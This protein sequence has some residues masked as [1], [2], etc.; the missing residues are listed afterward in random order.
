MKKKLLLFLFFSLFAL[1]LT[2]CYNYHELENLAIV[3]GL[4]I[5]KKDN[6]YVIGVLVANSKKQE[7]SSKEGQSQTIVY[8]GKGNS[9]MEAFYNIDLES[10]KQLYIGHLAVVVI[11]ENIAKNEIEKI[12]DI[13]I[14]SPESR[15]NFYVVIA[16]DAKAADVLKITSPLESYPS[17]NVSMNLKNTST[18]QGI[19]TDLTYS[20]F[21]ASMLTPGINPTLPTIKIS[22]SVK[23][24]EKQQNLESSAP[25]TKL[26][27]GTLAIFRNTNLL[28]YV[29]EDESRIIN[30]LN[31]RTSYSLESIKYKDNNIVFHLS[32]FKIK[33]QATLKDNKPIIDITFQATAAINEI[34]TNANLSDPKTISDINQL[35]EDKTKQQIL[36]TI[37]MTQNEFQSDIFGF[38]NLFYQK[39]PDYFSKI[40]LQW[41]EEEY[42]NIKINVNVDIDL[43][44]KGSLEQTIRREMYGKTTK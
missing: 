44:T 41:D 27:L 30:I 39:Y 21:I 18:Y 35:L 14:R 36:N 8:E 33:R 3:T 43:E 7:A 11:D 23:E 9:V 19:S 32:N 17:Q 6:Q 4:S 29:S 15:K 42:A 12:S 28:G 24:G 37:H 1:L 31:R 2:G 38:G 26:Q 10:P 5:D 25:E 40:E 13:L 22:G 16:R 20:E 34:N